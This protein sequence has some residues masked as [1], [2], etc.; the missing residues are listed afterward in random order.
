VPALKCHQC[1]KL[2][3]F[4]DMTLKQGGHMLRVLQA[5]TEEHTI[6]VR[7]LFWD[8]LQWANG[9]VTQGFGVT[10]DIASMLEQDM[11]TLAK[12]NPPHGRLL[13]AEFEGRPAGIACLRRIQADTGEIKRMFVRPAFRGNAIGRVLLEKL[14][15]EA[16]QIG[17]TRLRL[18]SA[19]FMIAAHALYRSAGFHETPAYEGSE[20]PKEFQS[21]WVFMEKTLE[22]DPGLPNTG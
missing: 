13:L 14:V 19:R 20:I 22:E 2:K 18:D 15:A 7:A 17:Y 8:Y 11:S 12:F 16:R 1:P 5:E 21:H 9:M 10:F 4:E 3:P 6:H